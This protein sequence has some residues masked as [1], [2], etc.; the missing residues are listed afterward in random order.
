M[1]KFRALQ[2]FVA[3]AAE[4][5]FTGAARRLDIS[6]PAVA[7]LINS[8]ERDLAV[9]LF[10]RSVHGLRLTADGQ[11]YLNDCQPLIEQLAAVDEALRAAS[12]RPRG[13]LAVGAHAQLAQHVVLPALPRFHARYPEIQIDIRTIG[14]LS[15]T[16]TSAIDVFALLGWPERADLVH[17][18][19]GQMRNL[20]CAAPAYWAKHGV[21]QHPSDLA[22]HTCLLLRTPEGTLLDLWQLER[23]DEKET[24]VVSGWLVSN[25][26]DILLDAALAGEGVARMGDLSIRPH[27]ES[28]RLVPVLLDWATRDSPP[29]NLLYRPNLR[30]IPRLRLFIDFIT[31]VVRELEA[32]RADDNSVRL[33][34]ERQHWHRRRYRSASA[35]ARKAG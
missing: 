34:A 33:S 18:R 9:R 15:D 1:D 35:A 11:N 28:G 6:V 17:R 16:E 3:A 12:T 29:I 2:Y 7:K 23:G 22:R 25:H 26:R 10:D 19:I 14:S 5:S 8:L 13:P 21:P 30:R 4:R 32:Q 31:A 20:I 24:V 27:I